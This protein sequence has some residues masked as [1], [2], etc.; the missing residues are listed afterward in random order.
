VK[1]AKS[2]TELFPNKIPEF[3]KDVQDIIQKLPSSA[4]AKEYVA[5]HGDQPGLGKPS[6][7]FAK[8]LCEVAVNSMATSER[9]TYVDDLMG[10]MLDITDFAI[11]PLIYRRQPSFYI[12]FGD[13]LLASKPDFAIFKGQPND[14]F[15]EIVGVGIENKRLHS[16][17][18]GLAQ[19]VA[20]SVAVSLLNFKL[21]NQLRPIAV[22]RLRGPYLS[23]L[24]ASFSVDFLRAV[25]S[26][27]YPKT[28]S[29]V[30]VLPKRP[31]NGF[32]GGY[33]LLLAEQRKLAF[34]ALYRVREF[35]L[36]FPN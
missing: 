4:S 36:N 19:A 3:S 35:V 33:N 1:D 21:D 23:V 32:H 28:D 9:E 22:L 17:N 11:G 29:I 6:Q 24:K 25:M 14:S 7:I 13:R 31:A 16:E 15:P 10:I 30:Q 12:D 5:K 2:I 26:G 34:E 20:T 8:R 27:N 18:S